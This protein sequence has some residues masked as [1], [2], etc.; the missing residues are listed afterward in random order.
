MH[1]A[2]SREV[3]GPVPQVEGLAQVSQP[4]AS[5]HP[6][7]EDRVDQAAQR[8]LG[9]DQAGEADPLRDGTDDDV[10]GR[11]HEHDL[12]HEQGD[13]PDVVGPPAL[14]EESPGP[15][16]APQ[17]RGVQPV[18]RSGT[19]QVRHRGHASEVEGESDRV[20]RDEGDDE[21]REVQHHHVPGILGPGQSGGE[22]CESRLH[23]ENERCRVQKPGEIDGD[24]G[25]ARLLGQLVHPHL[26][27]RDAVPARGPEEVAK[28]AGGRAGRI[29]GMR[30]PSHDDEGEEGEQRKGDQHPRALSHRT[31]YT[32]P[33]FRP[34]FLRV[35]A[36]LNPSASL[37]EWP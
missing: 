25:V 9:G 2:R 18:Q 1:H 14:E 35:S 11:L 4:S 10:A 29:A 36:R 16:E 31:F 33:A 5:P 20:V 13:R 24:A 3:D 6:V 32:A 17:A 7:A 12:E 8:E 30:E 15:D 21:G 34:G 37:L 19:A 23:E 28:A 27:Q 26:G 22:E